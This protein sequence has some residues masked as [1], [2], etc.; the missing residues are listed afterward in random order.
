MHLE[1]PPYPCGTY[2][3]SCSPVCGDGL[4]SGNEAA[5]AMVCDDGNLLSGDGCARDC[6]V[7]CGYTCSK[8]NMTT[9]KYCE[10]SCGDGL[11]AGQEEC[12]DGNTD[13]GDGCDTTC[14]I[15]AGWDCEN[16]TPSTC[17]EIDTTCENAIWLTGTG[18]FVTDNY[19]NEDNLNVMRISNSRYRLS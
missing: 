9:G 2:A 5:S 18:G 19:G 15:E 6:S 10:T 12:D 4:I 16:D 8:D 17:T 13:S 1:V 11:R 7:E 14:N 3:D